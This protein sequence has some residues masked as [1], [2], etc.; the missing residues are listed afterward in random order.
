MSNFLLEKNTRSLK[1]KT[2]CKHK[3]NKPLM[4]MIYN[5]AIKNVSLEPVAPQ[6]RTKPLRPASNAHVAAE[7]SEPKSADLLAV[8][9]VMGKWWTKKG[10]HPF[11]GK[12]L[13]K[14]GLCI[15]FISRQQIIF[16]CH[17]ASSCALAQ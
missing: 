7:L 3:G 4:I 5:N 10:G 13:G 9:T 17:L 8:T 6:K 1:N 12:N 2:V 11:G 16:D 14:K 15:P